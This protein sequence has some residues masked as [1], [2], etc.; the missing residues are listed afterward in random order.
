MRARSRILVLLAM[1]L[2]GAVVLRELVCGCAR[3][4][5]VVLQESIESTN[6]DMMNDECKVLVSVLSFCLSVS[7]SY[8]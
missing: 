5:G 2:L 3:C 6:L 1:T 8:W 7:V 4:V